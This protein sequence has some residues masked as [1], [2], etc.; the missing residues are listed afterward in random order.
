MTI[1]SKQGPLSAADLQA[2]WESSVDDSYSQPIVLAGEGKGFEVYTQA[3]AQ[4]ERLSQA[5]DYTTQA[6]YI[7]P[8]SGQ[9]GEPAAGSWARPS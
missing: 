4:V 5:V 2:I 6:L 8:W 7:L 1:D 9:S 3:F